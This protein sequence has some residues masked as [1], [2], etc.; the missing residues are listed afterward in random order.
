MQFQEVDTKDYKFLPVFQNN[1]GIS[2]DS[3]VKDEKTNEITINALPLPLMKRSEVQTAHAFLTD[4]SKIFGVLYGGLTAG[5]NVGQ[6][7]DPISIPSCHQKHHKEWF[8]FRINSQVFVWSFQAFYED[9]KT[10]LGSQKFTLTKIH[11]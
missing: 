10:C 4:T 8:D 2:N 5:L 3:Y 9:I 6:D 1:T 11:I 7:P